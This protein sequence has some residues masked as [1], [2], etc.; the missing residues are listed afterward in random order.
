MHQNNIEN[1]TSLHKH[2]L[3][4]NTG[5]SIVRPTLTKLIDV[6]VP[7]ISK[8]RILHFLTMSLIS[9]VSFAI[10]IRL[11]SSSMEHLY[12]FLIYLTRN[13]STQHTTPHRHR[14]KHRLNEGRANGT[15]HRAPRKRDQLTEIA[16][17]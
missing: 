15:P 2:M 5:R 11:F 7:S 16:A 8:R 10:S 9:F 3:R 6:V 12:I 4:Q 13:S 14:K 1:I 17:Y